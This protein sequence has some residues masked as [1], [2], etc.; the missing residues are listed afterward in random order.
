MKERIARELALAEY[1]KKASSKVTDIVMNYIDS[2]KPKESIKLDRN[3]FEI[4][5]VCDRG[6]IIRTE[7][8]ERLVY[9]NENHQRLKRTFKIYNYK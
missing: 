2:N 7:G 3:A 8:D 1:I 9:K 5:I 4:E 6:R